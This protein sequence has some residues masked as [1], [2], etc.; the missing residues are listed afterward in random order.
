[1]GLDDDIEGIVKEDTPMGKAVESLITVKPRET[2][3]PSDVELKTEL[4]EADVCNHT[5]AAIIG[6][7]LELKSLIG[8]NIIAE[9]IEVKERKLISK[10]RGS[11]KEI[12]EI[13]RNP[14]NV[15]ATEQQK[16]GFIN[17]LFR[18]QRAQ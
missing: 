11:R 3:G 12:V 7:A 4:S 8:P 15:I 6:R 17:K 9:I 16:G 13:A 2:A 10:D 14:D 1:M 5:R 18:P